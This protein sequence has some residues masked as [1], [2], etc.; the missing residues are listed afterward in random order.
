M[1]TCLPLLRLLCFTYRSICPVS[2]ASRRQVASFSFWL[3]LARLQRAR[4]LLRSCQRLWF[5]RRLGH[6][7][8]GVAGAGE[9]RAR[10]G[11]RRSLAGVLG[12]LCTRLPWCTAG[13]V[14][15]PAVRCTAI[16][17]CIR[18]RHTHRG[19][20]RSPAARASPQGGRTRRRHLHVLRRPCHRS[21]WRRGTPILPA[22]ARR[23]QAG[24]TT[25]APAEPED[26]AAHLRRRL[27]VIIR[28][29]PARHP[30]LRRLVLIHVPRTVDVL[31]HERVVAVEEQP[32]VIR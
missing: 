21:R 4:E 23:D 16:R 24:A 19:S 9:G 14:S 22:S 11:A 12:P 27:A 32:A 8:G 26:E 18:A 17:A 3:F 31:G 1:I 2:L 28:S 25:G 5:D 15:R 10:G 13:G 30:P 29:H 7:W 20:Y 6:R